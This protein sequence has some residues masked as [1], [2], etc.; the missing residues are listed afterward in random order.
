MAEKYCVPCNR[1]KEE[2]SEFFENGVTEAV[3]QSLS[4][5]TGFNAESGHNDCEDLKDANDCT[6]M[7]L[8]EQLPAY[9]VCEW[10][11]FTEQFVANQYNMN[12]AMICTICGLFNSL[13][14]VLLN[15]LSIDVK[16]EIRQ[17]TDGLSVSLKRNGD[18]IFRYS[19]WDDS[20]GIKKVGDGTVTGKSN[21]C[22]SVGKNKKISWT[23]KSITVSEFS[24]TSTS[25]VPLSRPSITI[26]VP[27]SSGSVVYEKRNVQGNIK[28]TINKTIELNKNGELGTGDGTDWIQFLSIYNNW[29]QDDEVNLYVKFKNNNVE[30]VPTC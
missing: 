30:N 4:N 15:N 29:Q 9:D 21:F 19:D 17:A 14:N 25:V 2:S 16:Y 18:W 24:Y 3:C 8:V 28:E 7:S 13:Q 26:R 1:L 12:E 23:I 27:N 5:N 20:N 10:K 22:M 6:I 11:E